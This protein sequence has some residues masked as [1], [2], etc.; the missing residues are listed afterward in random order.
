MLPIESDSAAPA[1][2]VEPALGSSSGGQ[3]DTAADGA[4]ATPLAAD[5]GLVRDEAGVDGPGASASADSPEEEEALEPRMPR[6]PA[7]PTEA[8]RRLRETTH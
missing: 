2:R 4:P 1:D 8:E 3:P 5:E 7:Q 6:E